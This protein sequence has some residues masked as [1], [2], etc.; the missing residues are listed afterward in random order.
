[1]L[2]TFG[3]DAFHSYWR[4]SA[5]GTDFAPLDAE[6]EC[7]VVVVGAGIVGLTAALEL[8]EQGAR[9]VLLEARRIGS[10]ATGYTTGKVSSLNGLIYARLSE[11]FGEGIARAYGEAGEAGLRTIAGLIERHG[12]ECDFRRKP[13]FTYT[14]TS[15]GREA[16]EREVTAAKKLGLPAE[17]VEAAEELPFPVEA[18]VRFGDQAEFHA[19]LYLQGLAV[20]AEMAGCSIHEQTRVTGVA[21]GEPCR[22][23]TDREV[24]V[25]AK[26]VILATHLPILDRGL[27]F[28]RTYAQRSYAIQARLRGEVPQGMYLSDEG[29]PHSLRAVP[30]PE[31]ERLLIGGES[32]KA[33]QD[34]PARRYEALERWALERFEVEAVEHRWATHDHIPHDGLPMIGRLWPSNGS[35]LTATGFQK[36]GLAMGTS[37][38]VAL[39]EL[40]LGREN[41][42]VKAFDSSRFGLLQGWSSLLKHNAD[43]GFR[44]LADRLRKR[45]HRP[46]LSK[47]EG[48]ILGDGLG[49]RAVYRDE[50]G[51]LRSF[52]ARC[53]HLGCIVG[54]NPAEKTWDCPC[55]GSR[56]D[57]RDGSVLEG[58]AVHAL[59]SQRG[60]ADG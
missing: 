45:S 9:V 40:A 6:V 18:A 33:G 30:T 12:I 48:A 11:D 2:T 59:E 42:W 24:A 55:H 16:L 1:V 53:P 35:L 19:L 23:E 20:A 43:D 47:G 5:P 44:F 54:F 13:N 58:P 46:A 27:Y 50:A 14:E 56:F 8:S 10:G 22:L 41:A 28:A 37:G 15:E 7:D 49:Q 51:V 3:Q 32:H 60:E 21:D 52:S 36:W 34:N 57:A 25:R 26:R 39:A 31:G 29:K 17:L 38:G 4:K